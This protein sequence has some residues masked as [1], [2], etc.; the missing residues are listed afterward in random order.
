MANL[1]VRTE[2]IGGAPYGEA[3][4]ITST[5]SAS[6]TTLHTM[7]DSTAIDAVWL[8]LWNTSTSDVTIGLILNADDS[9]DSTSVANATV[10]VV[11]PAESDL[12]VLQGDRFRVHA[13]GNATFT[14]AAYVIT[15]LPGDVRVTGH[16]DRITQPE[17]TI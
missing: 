4:R 11:V 5:S 15:G 13:S 10:R 6:P 3:V 16:I 7:T 1:E 17:L 9:A 8:H 14:I 2:C 12:W